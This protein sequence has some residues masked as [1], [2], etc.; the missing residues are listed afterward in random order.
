MFCKRDYNAYENG[1]GVSSTAYS[2]AIVSLTTSHLFF[3][4]AMGISKS[5]TYSGH[6]VDRCIDAIR[7]AGVVYAIASYN[8]SFSTCE[9]NRGVYETGRIALLK[10]D[11]TLEPAKITANKIYGTGQ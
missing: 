10:E 9:I 3:I 11:C 7:T 6:S 5:K 2:A 8:Q 1:A 4:E